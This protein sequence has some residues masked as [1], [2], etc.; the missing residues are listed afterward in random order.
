MGQPYC[1]V[2]GREKT[3]EN[4]GLVDS[5]ELGSYCRECLKL[6]QAEY[7][8]LRKVKHREILKELGE[9]KVRLAKLERELLFK[10]EETRASGSR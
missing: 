9:V 4:T 1:A 2:C 10:K 7:Y 5:G 3:E 8:Q 6:K